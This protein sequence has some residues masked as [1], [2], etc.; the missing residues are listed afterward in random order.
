MYYKMDGKTEVGK[1]IVEYCKSRGMSIADLS[2]K[3]GITHNRIRALIYGTQKI[4]RP[5]IVEKFRELG[6]DVTRGFDVVAKKSE[7]P[8]LTVRLDRVGPEV[9][10]QVA[11]ILHK[12]EVPVD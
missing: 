7:A 5:D 12:P 2:L 8:T 4:I 3:I 9:Y 6:V 11:R 10:N 1:D